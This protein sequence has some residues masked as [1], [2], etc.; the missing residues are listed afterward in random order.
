MSVKFSP[1]SIKKA[2][3]S[4]SLQKIGVCFSSRVLSLAIAAVA[5]VPMPGVAGTVPFIPAPVYGVALVHQG[6]GCS[7]GTAP[8]TYACGGVSATVSGFPFARISATEHDS[9][10]NANSGTVTLVYDYAVVGP[11]DGVAVPMLV[12]F[13]LGASASPPSSAGV[14]GSTALFGIGRPGESNLVLREVTSGGSVCGTF[15]FGTEFSG[16][17]AFNQP[18]GLLEQVFMRVET[19]G[20]SA[21]FCDSCFGDS[22]AFADPFISIDPAFLLTHPGY[23]LVLAAGIGNAPLAPSAVP[24][25]ETYTMMLVGLGILGFVA[26][27]RKQVAA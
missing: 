1:P 26:R 14:F 8:G 18:T 3:F 16:T 27:R 15:C 17:V 4:L 12:T 7:P 13:S 20:R 19:F 22:S 9:N 21:D 23:S 2:N 10:G 5:A 25:P 11:V 6:L 24:E